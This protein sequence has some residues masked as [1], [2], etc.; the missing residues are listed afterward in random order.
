MNYADAQLN[1]QNRFGNHG[2]KLF[3]PRRAN[4]NQLVSAAAANFLS[5]IYDDF[6]LGMNDLATQG[7]Y[8]YASDG[9]TILSGMWND[10][11]P[12]AANEQCVA[13]WEMAQYGGK[14]F[15]RPCDWLSF[16]ICELV[17]GIRFGKLNSNLDHYKVRLSNVCPT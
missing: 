16:S 8:V 4:T 17:T 13:Y 12:S 9:E 6:W 15:D 10:K 14:W 3:E 2:G 1:C 11:Q 5:G 7:Q